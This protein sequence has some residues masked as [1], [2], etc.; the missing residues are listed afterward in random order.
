[1][2]TVRDGALN[3]TGLIIR[4]YFTE[5]LPDIID[6]CG[7]KI[8]RLEPVSCQSYIKKKAIKTCFYLKILSSINV[9]EL[10]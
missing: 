8:I 3:R 4:N 7:V 5:Q 10:I 2:T 9:E 6:F 1:M